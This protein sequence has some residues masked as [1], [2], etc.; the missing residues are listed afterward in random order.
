[1]SDKKLIIADGHHRYE[2]ALA[3]SRENSWEA[4]QRVMM[5]FVNMHSAGLRI[6]ATHRLVSGLTGFDAAR[7]LE[8]LSEA[9]RVEAVG[10]AAEVKQRLG[11]PAPGVLRMAVAIAGQPWVHLVEAP[12][13]E[14]ALDVP[15]LHRRIL[16]R[17]LGIGEEAVREERFLRYV[18]G[19]D[20]ALSAVQNGEAQAA[21]LLQPT[22]VEQVAQVS[23]GGGVMPQ[24][25]TDFYPKLLSGLTIYRLE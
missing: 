4:A 12:R 14:G 18:R 23:F 16:E 5:T 7:L 1:M 3:Y 9:G 25:S 24:K 21:F 13:E 19:I 20:A 2:T 15:F 22:T 17:M 11:E 10:D 8:Q 6:L